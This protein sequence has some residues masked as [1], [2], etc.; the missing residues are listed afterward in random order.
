MAEYKA[1]LLKGL[2]TQAQNVLLKNGNTVEHDMPVFMSFP[3]TQVDINVATGSLYRSANIE[4]DTG[5]D[6][7]NKKV[8]IGIDTGAWVL[9][10]SVSGTKIYFNALRSSSA[11]IDFTVYVCISN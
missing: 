3:K 9:M 8:I 6:L 5:I 2:F 10:S 1:K 4:C 11:T 7:T